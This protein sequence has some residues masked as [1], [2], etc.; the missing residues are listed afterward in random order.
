[1]ASCIRL[2]IE[3]GA[4]RRICSISVC[5]VLVTLAAWGCG[6]AVEQAAT[7]ETPDEVVREYFLAVGRHDEADLKVSETRPADAY[8]LSSRPE[9]YRLYFAVRTGQVEY[10]TLDDSMTSVA[11]P[12][13]RFV[14]L[15][16]ETESSPWLVEEIGTGP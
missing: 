7:I 5:L 2:S 4:T 14:T 16:K 10:L 9:R 6:A 12:Q 8:D 13:L 1:V 3:G 15:V 11:G